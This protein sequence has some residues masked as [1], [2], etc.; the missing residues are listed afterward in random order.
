MKCVICRQAEVEPGKTTV[1]LERGGLTLVVKRV[2]ALVCPDCGEA[3]LDEAITARLLG[4]AESI[5]DA[6]AVVDVREFRPVTA[7][8]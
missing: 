3:Y 1:T 4:E 6:G 5:A 2:P 8:D 7:G